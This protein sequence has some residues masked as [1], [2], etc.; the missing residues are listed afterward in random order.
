[1]HPIEKLLNEYENADDEMRL[2]LFLTHPD[3]SGEFLEMDQQRTA[4]PANRHAA[5]TLQSHSWITYK[6][7]GL[8]RTTLLVCLM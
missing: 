6:G 3:L 2:H 7:F 4:V 8:S 1:M 5:Q